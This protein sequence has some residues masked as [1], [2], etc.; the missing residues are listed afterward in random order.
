M[1]LWALAWGR[2][3]ELGSRELGGVARRSWRGRRLGG[4]FPASVSPPR[5]VQPLCP[6]ASPERQS[7][8][9]A[10]CVNPRFLFPSS[11]Q[12]YG[13]AP[14]EEDEPKPAPVAPPPP[15][16]PPPPAAPA[17]DAETGA[18]SPPPPA[19]DDDAGAPDNDDDDDDDLQIVL[20]AP[21]GGAYPEAGVA[22]EDDDDDDFD[23][24]L[25]EDAVASAVP[26]RGADGEPAPGTAPP[27]PSPPGG[28]NV[29]NAFPGP[30][31][32]P[33]GV[34]GRAK[35]ALPK[36]AVNNDLPPALPSEAAPGQ[37]VRLPGQSRV[38]PEEY[39]EFLGLGH[40]EI[41]NLDI[42]L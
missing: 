13:E 5:R 40:G 15:L 42:D 19:P 30:P 14:P 29:S 21:A 24:Q 37:R 25:D 7:E 26:T 20:D 32:P 2:R 1:R 6:A 28:P 11:T 33:T 36:Y 8:S 3:E 41:F 12:L 10:T 17:T 39:R 18:G 4:A 34:P 23:V 9:Q 38:T 22:G 31:P 16:P 27:P 35:P